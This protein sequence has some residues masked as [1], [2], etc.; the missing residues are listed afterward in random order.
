MKL[1]ASIVLYKNNFSV[2]K[3]T[4]ESFLNT[5]FDIALYLI[6]NSP[7]DE[8][9]YVT[10]IDSRINY[11]HNDSN[12][13]FGVAH[14]IILRKSLDLGVEYHLVLNP[15]IYYG[16]G[17]LDKL[18]EYMDK[19]LSVANVTPKVYYPSG[20][21]QYLCKKLP[22]PMD[23]IGRRFIPFNSI[24]EKM[25]EK[26]EL[27][28]FGYARE[29]NVPSIDGCF[30]LLRTSH[31]KE[32]GLFDE[33]FFMYLEDVDLIRRLNEKYK[34]I[35]YPH[36][37]ITHIHAKESHKSKRLLFIHIQSAIYYFNKWGWFF[38]SKRRKTNKN[39]LVGL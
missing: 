37:S 10:K 11:I 6:D 12:L 20:K 17:V 2:L 39:L 29:L 14:N 15:D 21:L 27:H 24:V 9:R 38:D 5:K 7:T 30:M 4:I 35:F 36:V 18:V 16:D 28:S 13:G 3:K 23:L 32:V 1:N 25:N 19:N 34:T 33:N 22:T 26:F 8:L 31:L